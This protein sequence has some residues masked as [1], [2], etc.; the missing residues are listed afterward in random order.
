MLENR[1]LVDS[2]WEK[3]SINWE[4]REEYLREEDDRKYQEKID[5]RL[6]NEN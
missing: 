4:A 1:M 2:E 3:E 6:L 5:E